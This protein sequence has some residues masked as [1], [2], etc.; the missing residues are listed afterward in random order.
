MQAGLYFKKN[1]GS[2]GVKFCNVT[3]HSKSNIE[4]DKMM[5]KDMTCVDR[6]VST[7]L[8][9]DMKGR[10]KENTGKVSETNASQFKYIIKH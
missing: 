5:T 9:H 2:V 10:T 1:L 3:W 4:A 8:K 6:D 7:L